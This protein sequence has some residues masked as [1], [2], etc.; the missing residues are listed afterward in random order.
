M[1]RRSQ[2]VTLAAVAARDGARVDEATAWEISAA[3]GRVNARSEDFAEGPRAFAEKRPPKWT[4]KM[5][6]KCKRPPM[7]SCT[8]VVPLL[9]LISPLLSSADQAAYDS[10]ELL[11]R[12]LATVR[13]RG[14]AVPVAL[15]TIRR[16]A[17]EAQAKL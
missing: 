3:A 8:D 17:V 1:A 4:G 15:R 6:A 16:E 14:S 12:D 10:G 9:L 13:E 5:R 7:L 2:A 11:Q